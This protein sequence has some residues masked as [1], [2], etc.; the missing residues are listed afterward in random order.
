MRKGRMGWRTCG[1][2]VVLIVLTSLSS[3]VVAI[4]AAVK[5]FKGKDHY[6][7]E[8]EMQ[9]SADKVYET[10][11]RMAKELAP[12]VRILKQDD[13]DRLIEVTD[14]RQTA[15]VKAK[16]ISGEKSGV[17]VTA[18]VPVEEGEGKETKEAKGRELALRI[19]ERLCTEL[20]VQCNITKQ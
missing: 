13:A 2:S 18:N 20:K 14:G 16:P 8:A 3:C 4:P 12:K 1:A 7:A 11:V 9:I 10:T 6:V 17:I 19:I 15:S 5:Y